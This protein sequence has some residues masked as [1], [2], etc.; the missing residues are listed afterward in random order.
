[1]DSTGYVVICSFWILEHSAGT[2]KSSIR[3]VQIFVGHSQRQ[4]FQEFEF[5]PRA[6]GISIVKASYPIT[7]VTYNMASIILKLAIYGLHSFGMVTSRSIAGCLLSPDPSMTL[8][9]ELLAF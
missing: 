7:T 2:V 1:M 4:S 5:L 9:I 8:E 3:L 6:W